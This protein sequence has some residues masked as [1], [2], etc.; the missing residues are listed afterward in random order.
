MNLPQLTQVLTHPDMSTTNSDLKTLALEMLE[1]VPLSR[2]EGVVTQ[3]S[4]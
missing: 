4:H 2:I 1:L 3:E